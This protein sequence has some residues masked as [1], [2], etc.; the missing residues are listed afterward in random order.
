[1][2]G[3]PKHGRFTPEEIKRI[4]SLAENNIKELM[5]YFKD[6]KS[7]GGYQNEYLG[8]LDLAIYRAL[9]REN[10][11]DRYAMYLVGDMMWQVVVNSKGLIPVIDPIRKRLLK[12]STK[13]PVIILEKRL[14]G[15]MKYPYS[16]PDYKIDFSKKGKIFHMDIYTCPVYDFYKQFGD[17][18]M[19][20]FRKTWCT[21]DYTAAEHVVQ[22]GKYEREH[23]L[24]DGD[25]VC[26]MRWSIADGKASGTAGEAP[27]TP[28]R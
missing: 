3:S 12:L 17:E 1:M 8:L 23:T 6:V 11:E 5:P 27:E 24:A 25:K 7:V 4:I 16:K 20:L 14:K 22:G 2:D 18:E 9:K 15:M 26:A 13:D 28:S 21:F 19:E 10:V